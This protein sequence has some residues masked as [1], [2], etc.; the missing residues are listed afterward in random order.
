MTFVSI[1]CLGYISFLTNREKK[2]KWN[3][4]SHTN[5][6]NDDDIEQETLLWNIT[7]KSAKF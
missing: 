6:N 1:K 3:K 5:T 7:M 2:P 4:S